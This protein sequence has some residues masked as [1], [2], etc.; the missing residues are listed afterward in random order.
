MGNPRMTGVTEERYLEGAGDAVIMWFDLRLCGGIMLSTKG[1]GPENHWRQAVQTI[2]E[3]PHITAGS[4]LP[5][6][7]E[8]GVFFSFSIP[9]LI[10]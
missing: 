8:H 10:T 7:I 4:N 1:T 5:M 9:P 6:T 2:K 3:K